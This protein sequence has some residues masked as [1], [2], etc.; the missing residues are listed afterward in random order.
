MELGAGYILISKN[1]MKMG[2]FLKNE[3]KIGE[4]WNLEVN[5]NIDF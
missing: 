2:A 1:E 5:G 4:I 3:M